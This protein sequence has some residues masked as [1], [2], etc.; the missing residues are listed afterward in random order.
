MR[1]SGGMIGEET[2]LFGARLSGI[3]CNATGIWMEEEP[4][5]EGRFSKMV[6]CRD[7]GGRYA[8]EEEEEIRRVEDEV[9]GGEPGGGLSVEVI[10]E[11]EAYGCDSC[12]GRDVLDRIFPGDLEV[13][14]C[15]G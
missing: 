10:H 9:G 3:V 2:S 15:C 8:E 4:A 13:H 5:E 14:V 11:M 1:P 7:V 6:S 12:V